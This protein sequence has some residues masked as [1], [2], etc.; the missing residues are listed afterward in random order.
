MVSRKTKKYE[1]LGINPEFVLSA[2]RVLGHD[3]Y[4]LIEVIAAL[5]AMG[6]DTNR[7]NLLRYLSYGG[8]RLQKAK[9]AAYDHKVLKRV[10][11]RDPDGLFI[12][13]EY[14]LLGGAIKVCA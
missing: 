2:R 4:E 11:K 6:K 5:Q 10:V 3:A 12:S 1:Q 8:V 13:A 9:L 14:R 7:K